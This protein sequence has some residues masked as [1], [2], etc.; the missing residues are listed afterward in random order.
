MAE[1][2]IKEVRVYELDKYEDLY[3]EVYHSLRSCVLYS[4]DDSN[5]CGSPRNFVLDFSDSL[6]LVETGVFPNTTH[7]R[8]KRV[9]AKL[10]GSVPVGMSFHSLYEKSNEECQISLFPFG[11]LR[12]TESSGIS[13]ILPDKERWFVG[14][15]VDTVSKYILKKVLLGKE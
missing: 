4:L 7:S 1:K 9:H 12:F 2:I 6:D 5:F 14:V 3:R 15:K 10:V 11:V 13:S 8:P